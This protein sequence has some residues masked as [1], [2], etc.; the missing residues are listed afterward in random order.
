MD[1]KTGRQGHQPK[2]T[3]AAGEQIQM[4]DLQQPL[5]TE[6]RPASTDTPALQ[7]EDLPEAEPPLGPPDDPAGTAAGSPEPGR[8]EV[9]QA[10]QQTSCWSRVLACL[11]FLTALIAILFKMTLGANDIATDLLAGKSYLS[12]GESFLTYKRAPILTYYIR[13]SEILLLDV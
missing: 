6:S 12:G 5:A 2:P 7:L 11:F 8:A 9:E 1:G 3:A 4:A 10:R 13:K